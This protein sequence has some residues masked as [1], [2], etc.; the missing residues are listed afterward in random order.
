[1]MALHDQQEIKRDQKGHGKGELKRVIYGHLLIHTHLPHT[2]HDFEFCH[3]HST[4]DFDFAHTKASISTHKPQ[5]MPEA[6][7]QA[8]ALTQE[9]Y[10]QFLP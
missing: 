6:I 5:K 3:T 10:Y 9:K 1:M 8:F 2:M 7:Q 4:H